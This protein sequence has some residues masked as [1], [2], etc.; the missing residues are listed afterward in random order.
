MLGLAIALSRRRRRH[1][2]P[3]LKGPLYRVVAGHRRRQEYRAYQVGESPVLLELLGDRGGDDLVAAAKHISPARLAVH[4]L[5]WL[6]AG[7]DGSIVAT[8]RL[9]AQSLVGTDSPS[10]ALSIRGG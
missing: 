8:A 1:H 7:D 3:R 4:R 10:S 5:D 6:I 2:F 9:S